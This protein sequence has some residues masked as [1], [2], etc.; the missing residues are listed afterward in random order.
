MRHRLLDVAARLCV[1]DGLHTLTLDAVAR[2]AGV[3][4]GGLLHHFP[5]KQAL[6]EALSEACLED[7]NLRIQKQIQKDKVPQGRFSRAYLLV[8]ASTGSDPDSEKWN[9]LAAVFIAD[10]D[11]RAAW[12]KWLV[13]RLAEHDESEGTIGATLARLA[14]DGLWLSDFSGSPGISQ[15]KRSKLIAHLIKMTQTGNA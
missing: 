4:K 1:E 14:A 12:S 10:S 8:T 2:E 7:L 9:N 15:A 11:M 6:M 13:K 3:S 5:S